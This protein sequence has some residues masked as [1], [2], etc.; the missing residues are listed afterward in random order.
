M[1]GIRPFFFSKNICIIQNG[2]YDKLNSFCAGH[3]TLGP[4]LGRLGAFTVAPVDV[5]LNTLKAPLSAIEDL[6]LAVINLLG[7]AL[8]NKCSIKFAI[9]YTEACITQVAQTAISLVMAI[10]KLVYQVCIILLDPSKARPV[11][12]HDCSKV[13]ILAPN[14]T[15]F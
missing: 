8:S 13:A 7:A 3:P 10:V 4:T 11:Y 15:P 14:Y 2:M 1:E 12:Y 6:A 9:F 5:F